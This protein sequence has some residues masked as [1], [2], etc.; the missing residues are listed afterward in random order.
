MLKELFSLKIKMQ[1]HKVLSNSFF[2]DV[3]ILRQFGSAY[4]HQSTQNHETEFTKTAFETF[5]TSV[6]N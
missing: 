4:M 1:F 2:R 5:L 6:I 3:P